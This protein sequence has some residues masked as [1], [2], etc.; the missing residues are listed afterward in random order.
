[1]RKTELRFIKTEGARDSLQLPQFVQAAKDWLFDCEYRQHS[2]STIATRRIVTDKL[3]WFLDQRACEQCG[4]SEVRQFLAYLNRGHQDAEG[5]WGNSRFN[6]PVRPRTVH[7]YHGHLR[8]FFA[9]LVTEGILDISPMDKLAAPVTRSDQV[10]PF[11]Q[12]QIEALL[13]AA[14]RSRA[15]RLNE[16]IVMFLL[17]TGARASELCD[18]KMKDIG[19]DGRRCT[20]RGKGNKHRSLFFGRRTTKAL[21]HTLKEEAR[22]PEEPLFL[23]DRGT[24]AGEPLTRSGL[25]QL[26]NRLG[27]SAGLQSTRCSPHTFR[28]TFAVEFLRGGNV[29]GLK[30]ILGHT[31]LHMVNRYV[32]L[33]QADVENQ[34]R[35]FSPGDRL[36]ARK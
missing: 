10:Q 18:L 30:E 20:V 22:E 24:G 27:K 12:T 7:T 25:L 4:T 13:T 26:I 3:S 29:F 8:T 6:K 32:A 11:T 34:H 16:A 1:M 2:T 15:P 19:L 9:W 23:A 21:W 17:D 35:Q 36:G 31:T 33:A 14:K 28:H 5:R